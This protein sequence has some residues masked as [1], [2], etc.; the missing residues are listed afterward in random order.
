[1]F[2]PLRAEVL[3]AKANNKINNQWICCQKNTLLDSLHVFRVLLL[4][5]RNVQK[6]PQVRLYIGGEI[7]E[8]TARFL[9]DRPSM[10]APWQRFDGNTGCIGR[11][12]HWDGF[13]QLWG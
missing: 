1:M 13:L 12:S 4:S 7:F 10:N 3:K 9:A 11:S 8:G 2:A 5:R 6:A